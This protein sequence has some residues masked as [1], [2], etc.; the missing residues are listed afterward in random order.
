MLSRETGDFSESSNDVLGTH[1]SGRALQSTIMVACGNA[2]LP[3][4]RFAGPSDLTPEMY[5]KASQ[6]PASV[7]PE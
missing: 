7:T 5:G 3:R 1:T 4:M 6:P 2:T